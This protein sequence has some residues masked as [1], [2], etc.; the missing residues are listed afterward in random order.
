MWF[1]QKRAL[2]EPIQEK[3][4]AFSTKLVSS[5]WLRNLKSWHGIRELRIHG[6]KLSADTT[7]QQRDEDIDMSDKPDEGT[8]HSEAYSCANI[9][10]NWMEQQKEFSTTQLM[11]MRHIRAISLHRRSDL[12]SN[13]SYY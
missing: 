2:D 9:L 11:L 13:R 3:A 12:R 1:L 6:E 4:L 5:G 7:A 8:S 10:F